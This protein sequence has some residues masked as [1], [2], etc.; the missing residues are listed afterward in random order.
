MSGNFEKLHQKEN[1]ILSHDVQRTKARLEAI[2]TL[3]KSVK[4]KADTPGQWRKMQKLRIIL[5]V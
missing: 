5:P 3:L 2:E 1:L 4:D